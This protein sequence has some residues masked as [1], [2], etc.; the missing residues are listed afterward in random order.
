MIIKEAL[1]DYIKVKRETEEKWT[2]EKVKCNGSDEAVIMKKVGE[3]G[4]GNKEL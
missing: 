3:G 2:M 1:E 4:A